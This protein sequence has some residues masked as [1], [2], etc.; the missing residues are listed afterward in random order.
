MNIKVESNGL[1]ADRVHFLMCSVHVRGSGAAREGNESLP[2][3]HHR[4]LRRASHSRQV[5]LVLFFLSTH[6]VVM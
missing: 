3:G 6:V 1:F 4:P 2:E 5:C